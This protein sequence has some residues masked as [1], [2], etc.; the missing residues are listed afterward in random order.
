MAGKSKIGMMAMTSLMLALTIALPAHGQHPKQDRPAS[1]DRPA[2]QRQSAPRRENSRPARQDR[3]ASRQNSRPTPYGGR[4][5]SR[6]YPQQS[7]PSY[8][9][10]RTPQRYGG[11]YP[12]SQ[13]AARPP[14]TSRPTGPAYSQQ[15]QYRTSGEVPHPPSQAQRQPNP[16]ASYGQGRNVP[17]PPTT[18]RVPFSQTQGREVAHPPNEP[19]N[20]GQGQA[21]GYPQRPAQQEVPRPP[22]ANSFTRDVPRPPASQ[23][24]GGDW[25]KS[26]RDLPLADQ[27]KALQSDPQFRR[28]PAQQQQRLE[29]RLQN[30]STLPRD[31][32]QRRLNRI[33]TWEHLTPQ[34]KQQARQLATQWQ[35]MPQGRRQAMKTAIGDLRAMPP[36]QRE[37][38]LN[39]ERFKGMFSDQERNMLRETTKLPLAPAQSVPRP[40]QQ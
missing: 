24:H 25:L 26:H 18:S 13:Q 22:Q 3:S 39:S 27:Q 35:Q 10:A 20:R 11:G 38:V 6:P 34:Q 21:A 4:M 31:E 19:T 17:R 28:L 1:H 33:E 29:N 32:Q 2:P 40:P 14:M 8:P 23:R 5:Q 36:D 30:F 15:N 9:Q 37:Q 7:R 12:P 16:P